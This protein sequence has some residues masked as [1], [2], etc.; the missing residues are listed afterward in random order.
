[1]INENFVILGALISIVG[2]LSYLKDT[3]KGK[4]KPNRATWFLVSL[5]PLLAV[6][7][8][9]S[10]GVGI[11]SLTT[12]MAG[13]MPLLIFLASFINKKSVWK[14][15]KFDYACGYLSLIGLVLWRVTGSGNYAIIFALIA[16]GLA[17]LPTVIKSYKFPETENYHAFLGG[18]IS[19]GIALLTI[20]SWY[21]ANF[22]FPVYLFLVD[23][24]MI[25]LIKYKLGV[26]YTRALST[27][28]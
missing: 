4:I 5:P 15:T 17:T 16:D 13:F 20:N 22:A 6:S 25:G 18:L 14:L 7:G 21:F 8:E 10:E 3:I 12:F 24:L 19:A 26:E 11:R 27:S 2:T 1:M 23:I 28:K 9:I